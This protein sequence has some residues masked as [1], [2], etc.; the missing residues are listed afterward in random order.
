MR[1]RI[2]RRIQWI[3]IALIV[4]LPSCHQLS[5][6]AD[7]VDKIHALE[8][9]V[10]RLE[11]RVFRNENDR[12]DPDDNQNINASQRCQGITRKGLRCKRMV[13]DGRYCWQHK[14]QE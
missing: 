8:E 9:R 6:D 11:Q 12:Y 3:L 5:Q 14:D 7:P 2:S 4:S 13:K 10:D 1:K